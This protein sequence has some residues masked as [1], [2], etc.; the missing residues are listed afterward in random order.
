MRSNPDS[1]R[2]SS[3]SDH[4]RRPELEVLLGRV[5]R[6]DRSSF[7]RVYDLVAARVFGMVVRVLRD[8]AQSEE[9]AQDVLVE[10]WR[11][12]ARYEP[13][14]GSAMAWVMT[15]AHRRAIDRVRSAGAGA[16]RE[17]RVARMDVRRPFDEVAEAV[18]GNLERE[19]LRRCLAGLTE[20]QRE[21]VTFAYF[22]GYSYRE[23]AELLKVPLGTI[24]ARMR[25][26]LIRLRDCLGVER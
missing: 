7:E 8:R 25:D 22:G 9:V 10:V 5:A 3:R 16:E 20:L 21:S 18:E 23:V 14:R 26:G 4:G 6:G 1:E 17:D 11:S 12:A 15:I 13:S 19:R 2:E 24:K